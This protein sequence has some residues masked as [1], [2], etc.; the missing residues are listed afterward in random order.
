MTRK[1]WKHV[2]NVDGEHFFAP[3]DVAVDTL[4]SWSRGDGFTRYLT[5]SAHDFT[6]F[7]HELYFLDISSDGNGNGIKHINPNERDVDRLSTTEFDDVENIETFNNGLVF[8]GLS[9]ED[10]ESGGNTPHL[11]YLDQ[12]GSQHDLNTFGFFGNTLEV[13]GETLHVESSFSDDEYLTVDSSWTVT[14]HF[15]ETLV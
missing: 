11:A 15:S 13:V 5:D 3:T 9:F 12:S 1:Q 7:N 14:P 6:V 2:A 8:V 10:G 4:I